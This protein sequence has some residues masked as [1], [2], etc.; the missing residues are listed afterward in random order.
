MRAGERALHAGGVVEVGGGDLARPPR[1]A[2]SRPCRSG[3]RVTARTRELAAVSARMARASPPP[4]APVAPNTV[5]IFF[6]M[7][8]LLRSDQAGKFCSC[9]FALRGRN[10][11]MCHRTQRSRA[12]RK[13][14]HAAF[15]RATHDSRGV[16]RTLAQAEHDDIG[17][18]RRQ[19]DVDARVVRQRLRDV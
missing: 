12:E 8:L 14:Q 7:S 11:E 5:M 10:I 19:V 13:Q 4:C 9:A 15:P 6:V 17:L 2:P 18:H 16:G 1:R 3:L